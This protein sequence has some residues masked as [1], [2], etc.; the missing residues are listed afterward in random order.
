M[1]MFL[2]L[3]AE[4]L[5]TFL[6]FFFFGNLVAETASVFFYAKNVEKVQSNAVAIL[7][8]WN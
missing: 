7:S 6:A 1:Q 8:K 3:N 5:E 2:G 4:V